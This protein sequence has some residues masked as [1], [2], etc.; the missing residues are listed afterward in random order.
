M[1]AAPKPRAADRKLAEYERKGEL[2]DWREIV[3][4]IV[5]RR[6]KGI[7]EIRKDCKGRGVD[8]I[9]HVYGHGRDKDDWRERPSSMLATC[10]KCHPQAIRHKPAG[11]K[12][13]WVEEILER[14]NGGAAKT[15]EAATA[16]AGGSETE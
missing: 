6:S 9:H 13:A 5:L 15:I 14:I 8:D 2:K 4:A 10:R 1:I 11:P 3:R 7:C 16:A 12:L